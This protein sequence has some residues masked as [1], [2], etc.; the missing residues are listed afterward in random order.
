MSVRLYSQN[1]WTKY[2]NQYTSH[3][4]N[5]CFGRQNQTGFFNFNRRLLITHLRTWIQPVLWP[6]C[7]KL[8]AHKLDFATLTMCIE[9]LGLMND[10]AMTFIELPM[11]YLFPSAVDLFQFRALLAS[12]NHV[13]FVDFIWISKHVIQATLDSMDLNIE[14]IIQRASIIVLANSD[15][16]STH[17]D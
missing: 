1:V 8:F 15:L 5:I 9:L 13:T 11:I 14:S 16:T 12:V 7:A 10:D 6:F 17:L 3:N 4:I 2:A